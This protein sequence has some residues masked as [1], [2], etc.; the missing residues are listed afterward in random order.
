[1]LTAQS[2]YQYQ[3]KLKQWGFKKYRMGAK[4]WIYVKRQIEKR[5][6]LEKASEVFI[7]GVQCPRNVVQ[8]EIRRQ[9][10]ETA[11]EIYNTGVIGSLGVTG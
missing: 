1:M 4:K 7:D 6:K 11:M 9:G 10:F 8:A 5:N 2:N 3:A